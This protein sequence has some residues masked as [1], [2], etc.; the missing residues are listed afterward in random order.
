MLLAHCFLGRSHLDLWLQLYG[1]HR[2]GS[3]KSCAQSLCTKLVQDVCD[4]D[5]NAFSEHVSV[6]GPVLHYKSV[7]YQMQIPSHQGC[8]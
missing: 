5:Q 7:G 6:E 1:L 3:F 2:R 4:S 8:I